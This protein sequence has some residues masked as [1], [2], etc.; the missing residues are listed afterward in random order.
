MRSK[1]EAADY[2]YFNDPDL[3][4]IKIKQETITSI[5]QNLP[6]LPD[7]KLESLMSQGLTYY[8][9]EILINDSELSELL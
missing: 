8:E 2:R 1:E 5:G 3:P 4:I 7:K 9:A 6:E